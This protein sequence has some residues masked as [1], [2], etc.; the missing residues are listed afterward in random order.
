MWWE[1]KKKKIIWIWEIL[2]TPPYHCSGMVSIT[3]LLSLL[4]VHH[5]SFPSYMPYHHYF[6]PDIIYYHTTPH[7]SLYRSSC[8]EQQWLLTF[9]CVT[10][11]CPRAQHCIPRTIWKTKKNCGRNEE[12]LH[13]NARWKHPCG[14]THTS[15][16]ASVPV[17]ATRGGKSNAKGMPC[18]SWTKAYVRGLYRYE[19]WCR[20]PT[21]FGSQRARKN[22]WISA[23]DFFTCNFRQQR[24]RISKSMW[25]STRQTNFSCDFQLATC[26]SPL[27]LEG[28]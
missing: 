24:V 6:L 5:S 16:S 20:P 17:L 28:I 21:T 27:R 11:T 3:P 25:R 15:T 23:E 7:I 1:E 9:A 12:K 26:T 19:A 4:Y 13:C 8:S 2:A 22:L 18:S 10:T 14:S